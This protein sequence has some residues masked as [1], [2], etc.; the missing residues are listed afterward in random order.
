MRLQKGEI[1][2][3]DKKTDKPESELIWEEIK[4]LPIA[5]FALPNQT[6]KQHVSRLEVPGTKLL[7]R[8]TST[9][10]LPALEEALNNVVATHGKRYEVELA[11]GYTVI[12]RASI[13]KE[14][15]KKALAPFIVV[16]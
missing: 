12:R 16:K 7:L 4:D 10:A 13:Q 3:K 15:I 11:E 2:S 8:L 1:M 6:I 14:E 5:M 9:A